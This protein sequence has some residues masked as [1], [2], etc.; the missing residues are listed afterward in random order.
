MPPDPRDVIPLPAAAPQEAEGIPATAALLTADQ[1]AA[2]L[3]LDRRTVERRDAAGQIPGSC[4]VGHARRFVRAEVEA[5]INQGCPP[6]KGR[7]KAAL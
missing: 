2:L 6:A 4:K 1:L 5:W 7:K 3:Q